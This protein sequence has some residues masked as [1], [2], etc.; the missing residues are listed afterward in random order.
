LTAAEPSAE[1]VQV[2]VSKAA[3]ASFIC[4]L[5]AL[6]CFVPGLIAIID[7]GVLDPRSDLENDNIF[8]C[9]NQD[10]R[11]RGAEPGLSIEPAEAT[12]SLPVNDPML[13]R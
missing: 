6:V 2:R 4:S 7:P 12:D 10:D 3:I 13:S 11:I 9:W 1:R 5:L 8:T